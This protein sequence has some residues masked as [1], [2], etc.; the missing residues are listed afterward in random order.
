M[1]GDVAAGADPNPIMFPCVIEELDEPERARRASDQ[2]IVQCNAHHPRAFGALF[3]QEIEAIHHVAG[4]FVGGAE[5]VILIEPIVICV[6][7]VGHDETLSVADVN[8]ERQLMAEI[9]AI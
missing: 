4:E 7:R 1:L 8:P 6:I 9:V 2:T 3:V 5:S